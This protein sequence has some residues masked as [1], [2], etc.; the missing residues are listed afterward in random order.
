MRIIVRFVIVVVALSVALTLKWWLPGY[1]VNQDKVAR[2]QLGQMAAQAAPLIATLEAYHAAHGHYPIAADRLDVP[3]MRLANGM[4]WVIYMPGTLGRIAARG[5]GAHCVADELRLPFSNAPL[6][7]DGL[8]RI[9]RFETACVSGYR[10]YTLQ[11]PNLHEDQP[12]QIERWGVYA[13]S[14][15]QWTLGWCSH[16]TGRSGTPVRTARDGFCRR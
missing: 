13:S 14:T 9:E 4:P 3:I 1:L 6:T 8:A 7:T 10:S 2:A 5:A 11:S 16:E 12:S 15:R